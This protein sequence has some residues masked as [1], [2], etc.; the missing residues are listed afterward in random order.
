MNDLV[1][2]LGGSKQSHGRLSEDAQRQRDSGASGGQGRDSEQHGQCRGRPEGVSLQGREHDARVHHDAETGDTGDRGEHRGTAAEHGGDGAQEAPIKRQHV[3]IA[4]QPEDVAE[5]GNDQERCA[6]FDD[7]RRR[8]PHSPEHKRLTELEYEEE[9]A[10]SERSERE[11][12]RHE[13]ERARAR[14][15]D[16]AHDSREAHDAAAEA[17]QE[18]V[19]DNRRFPIMMLHYR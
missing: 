11:E 4:E 10:D 12:H 5:H 16:E 8:C 1:N 9:A 2:L 19:D 13:E 3:Q 14:V 6:P 18:Q 15:D 7:C 17:T